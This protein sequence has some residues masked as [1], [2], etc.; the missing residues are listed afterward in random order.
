MLF[1]HSEGKSLHGPI[2]VVQLRH[3]KD[4]NKTNSCGN[5]G[6]GTGLINVIDSCFI[7]KSYSMYVDI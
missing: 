3:A 6:T 1:P 4:L 2:G 7:Y 5:E